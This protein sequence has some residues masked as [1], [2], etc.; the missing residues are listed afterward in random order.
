MTAR[1]SRQSSAGHAM[2]DLSLHRV[3]PIALPD[4]VK[5]R[6]LL[7][8]TQQSLVGHSDRP[9]YLQ[10]LPQASVQVATCALL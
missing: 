1:G 4:G 10:N 9:F 2:L 8:S 3:C 7:R 5:D 6:P